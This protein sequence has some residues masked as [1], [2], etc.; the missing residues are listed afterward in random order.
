[1]AVPIIGENR[2]TSEDPEFASLSDEDRE[3]LA[4]L[5]DQHPEDPNGP[6]EDGNDGEP[7]STAFFL[8]IDRKGNIGVNPDVTAK[9]APDRVATADDVFSACSV[10]LSDLNAG[11]A[12]QLTTQQMAQMGAMMQQ[13]QLQQQEEARIRA[14][15]IAAQNKG[16]DKR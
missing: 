13:Q 3:R 14:Q 9:F 16:F 5:A 10:A 11:K 8:V 6:S 12:A 4:A 2:T 7:V 15:M 1:M